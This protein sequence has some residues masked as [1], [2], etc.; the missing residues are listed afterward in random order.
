LV[1]A[2]LPVA[3]NPTRYFIFHWGPFALNS[4]EVKTQTCIRYDSQA[5]VYVS[6]CAEFG[7][8]SQGATEEEAERAIQSAINLFVITCY[9]HEILHSTLKRLRSAA[10]AEAQAV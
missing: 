5:G 4:F 2:S 8:V 10:P 1:F 3:I 7:L 6:S 9:E